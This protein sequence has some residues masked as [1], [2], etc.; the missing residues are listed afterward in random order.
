M[1]EV[2]G[3]DNERVPPGRDNADLV[4]HLRELAQGIEDG[5]HGQCHLAAVIVMDEDCVVRLYNRTS[6]HVVTTE[7]LG[8]FE[9]VKHH[10]L[11]DIH[12]EDDGD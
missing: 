12:P 7:F 2:V 9:V 1:G 3:F 11:N 6:R 4:E 5:K 10:I 8:I